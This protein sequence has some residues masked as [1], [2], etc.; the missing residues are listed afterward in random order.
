[1]KYNNNKYT[2][3]RYFICFLVSVVLLGICTICGFL[4][5]ILDSAAQ[6]DGLENSTCN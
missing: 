4:I 1:M 3:Y 2:L 6:S 5:L